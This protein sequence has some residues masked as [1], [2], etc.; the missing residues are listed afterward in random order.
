MGWT[1]WIAFRN[2]ILLE[3][4]LNMV[5]YHVVIIISSMGNTEF[6][7][8]LYVSVQTPS[9]GLEFPPNRLTIDSFD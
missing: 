2:L 7:E 5:C 6:F 3:A 1:Q 9:R 4:H 8:T